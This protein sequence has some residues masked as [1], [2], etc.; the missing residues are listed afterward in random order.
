[1]NRFTFP[2]GLAGSK[3]QGKLGMG[4]VEEQIVGSSP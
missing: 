4:K 2:K 3:V 1:M